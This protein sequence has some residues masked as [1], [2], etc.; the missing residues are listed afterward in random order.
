[1]MTMMASP[2]VVCTWTVASS[3]E[4]KTKYR[5]EVKEL[6]VTSGVWINN[7]ADVI[8]KFSSVSIMLQFDGLR[9][10]RS[11]GRACF[12]YWAAGSGGSMRLALQSQDQLLDIDWHRLA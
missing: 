6:Q 8:A 2:P 10:W 1:M 3:A 4:A 12:Y 5:E 9:G 7:T 11:R